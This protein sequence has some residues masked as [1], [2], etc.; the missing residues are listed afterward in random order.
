VILAP[1]G[2]EIEVEPEHDY[3]QP[4]FDQLVGEIE[5]VY[6]FDEI[7]FSDGDCVLDI[8]AHVGIVAIYLALRHPEITIYAYEPMP[9]NYESMLKNLRS[10]GVKSVIPHR[11]AVA[12]KAGTMQMARGRHSGE[13][14]AFHDVGERT[15][16]RATTLAAIFRKH[17]L[18]RVR[19]A[20]LDCE[21][22]EH[23]I[24]DTAG[25]LL[26]RI[27]HF[28]VELH[29]NQVLKDMGYTMADTEAK[30]PAHKVRWQRTDVT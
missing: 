1:N 26:D 15:K 18:R 9:W 22:A 19:L 27:D 24:L 11:L 6:A 25:A 2:V 10:N 29:L 7:S 21:G 23:G 4:F 5:G 3:P 13:G 12:A 20:K 17:K 30:L 14:G 8:G 16:V 28:R